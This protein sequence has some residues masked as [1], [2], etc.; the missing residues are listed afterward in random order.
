MLSGEL[1]S[2]RVLLCVACVV[3]QGLEASQPV[4]K[5][6]DDQD[7]HSL[8]EDSQDHS[9]HERQP[10]S[11][12]NV[13][14]LEL[15]PINS[16]I[17]EKHTSSDN[18]IDYDQEYDHD[19]HHNHNDSLHDGSQEHLTHE[20]QPANDDNM[21][22]HEP[23]KSFIREIHTVSDN[24]K[25]YDHDHDH[26]HHHKEEEEYDTESVSDYQMS[27]TSWLEDLLSTD[28]TGPIN[29]DHTDYFHDE[30]TIQLHI[31]H[32]GHDQHQHND[33]DDDHHEL[34]ALSLKTWLVS[35]CSIAVISLVSF[36]PPHPCDLPDPRWASPLWPPYHFYRA[37]TGTPSPSPS[38]SS[39]LHLLP[40]GTPCSP[41]W[42][43]WL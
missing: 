38:L 15:K 16:H 2:V 23:V 30:S 37:D 40:A 11:Y 18:T 26:D 28:Q 19:H 12:E 9:T 20:K 39:A 13:E 8:H 6:Q 4:T 27:L 25:D 21:E 41:Y 32:T 42:S 35:L 17:K 22:N 5:V 43:P 29:D 3:T 34:P 31:D 36:A 14:H 24:A 33:N 1:C 7:N 10:A